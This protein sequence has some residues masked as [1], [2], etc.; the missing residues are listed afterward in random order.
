MVTAVHA[1][2]TQSPANRERI[3]W[4]LLTDLPVDDLTTAVRLLER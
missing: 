4:K 1:Y 3:D 2:E